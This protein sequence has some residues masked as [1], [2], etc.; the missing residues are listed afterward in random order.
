ME[1]YCGHSNRM[2]AKA[3]SLAIDRLGQCPNIVGYV[4]HNDASAG[5]IIREGGWEIIEY[6]DAGHSVKAFERRVTNFNRRNC[7]VMRGIEGALKS[8][9]ATLLKSDEPV[10]EK[11]RQWNNALNHLSGDHSNC[12]HG[13]CNTTKWDLAEDSDA[14]DSLKSFHRMKLKFATK[15]VHWG[16]TWNARMMCAVLENNMKGWK[17]VLFHELGLDRVPE[18]VEIHVKN[19]RFP[20][21]QNIPVFP[22]VVKSAQWEPHYPPR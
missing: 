2:E 17:E 18:D 15:D 1:N 11:V 20:G 9:M 8:W 6:L 19:A 21:L 16:F 10:E 7:Q 14:V 3:L 12:R 4:P 13:D 22:R 5:K